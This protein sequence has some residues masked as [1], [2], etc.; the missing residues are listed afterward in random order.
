MP[1]IME[2]RMKQMMEARREINAQFGAVKAKAVPY[3]EGI[4]CY[5]EDTVVKLALLSNEIQREHSSQERAEMI[6]AFE[7]LLSEVKAREDAPEKILLWPEGKMPAETEYTD[8]SDHRYNHDP[9]FRPYLIEMLLPEDVTPKGALALCAGGDH[10][11]AVVHEAYQTAK[12]FNALG[13]QCFLILNR[14]NHNPWN[15]KEVGADCAR[16]LRYIRKN[17]AKYRI[18]PHQV[19]FAGFSNGGLSG[20]QTIAYYSGEKK[21]QDYFPDYEP[22]ELDAYYGAPD[23][24]LCVYGPRFVGGTIDWEGVV[25]PPVFYAVGREDTAL[26]NLNYV[27]PEM[28]AHG[29]PAEIHT[30]AGVPHGKAGSSIMNDSYA[31]FDLWVPLADAFMQDV[32]QKAGR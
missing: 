18:D 16:A 12:D 9:D 11:E 2:E 26:D 32:Y 25:Y 19:A 20:E 30:F 5:E 6:R 1:D 21:V 24:F 22:D 27:Y 4:P 10:A 23:A 15:G 8:N 14:T 3:W 28:L 7:A 31:N 17:A 13:Y 29:V